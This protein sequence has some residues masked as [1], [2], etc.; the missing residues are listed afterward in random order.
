LVF[1]AAKT[2]YAQIELFPASSVVSMHS[3]LRER[4]QR[5]F[6]VRDIS[7]PGKTHQIA[8]LNYRYS[9]KLALNLPIYLDFQYWLNLCYS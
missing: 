5:D 8:A 4:K 6:M 3:A 7:R 2:I 1:I 9:P